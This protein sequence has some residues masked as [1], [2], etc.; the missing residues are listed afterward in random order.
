MTVW[1]FTSATSPSVRGG[2]ASLARQ[3][4]YLEAIL[5]LC[6]KICF[7]IGVLFSRLPY[8]CFTHKR[9]LSCAVSVLAD[10]N[11][12]QYCAIRTMLRCSSLCG[13]NLVCSFLHVL[14]CSRNLSHTLLITMWAQCVRGLPAL[15]SAGAFGLAD[16]PKNVAW[17]RG[18]S[19]SNRKT[20]FL[21]TSVFKDF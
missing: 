6:N 14:S 12:M 19:F 9:F 3:H 10:L 11:F 17:R 2:G 16:S 18:S 15:F 7:T 21:R 5:V 20:H 4:W 13:S 8:R 1:V